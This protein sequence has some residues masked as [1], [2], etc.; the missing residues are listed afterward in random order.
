MP[1]PFTFVAKNRL[2]PRQLDRER[3]RVSVSVEFIERHEP[4]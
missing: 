4:A 2:K 1:S 3:E